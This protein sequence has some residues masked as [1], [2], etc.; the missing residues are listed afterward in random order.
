MQGFDLTKDN[1]EAFIQGV[2]LE[3]AKRVFAAA[4][5]L[6]VTLFGKLSIAYPPASVRGEYPHARTFGGRNAVTIYPQ[7]IKQIANEGSTQIG[8]LKNAFYMGILEEDKGRLG[9]L[10]LYK[11][12]R[13]E[14]MSILGGHGYALVKT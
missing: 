13:P 1:T 7:Q 11:E 8:Y 6:Q 12:L 2:R 4:T 5:H 14:L 3:L 9:L 10:K